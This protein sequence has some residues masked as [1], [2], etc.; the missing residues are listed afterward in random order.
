[1]SR[2]YYNDDDA[3]ERQ[4]LQGGHAD[5]EYDD[6]DDGDQQVEEDEEEHEYDDEHQRYDPESY[7]SQYS[8]QPSRPSFASSLIG[9][10]NFDSSSTGHS[11]MVVRE[12]VELVHDEEDDDDEE[13]E[14][15]I[16]VDSDV[17]QEVASAAER[18]RKALEMIQPQKCNNRIFL[19]L[20]GVVAAMAC[21]F[22]IL[23]PAYY[24]RLFVVG[25]LYIVLWLSFATCAVSMGVCPGRR[26]PHSHCALA[27]YV[28]TLAA[29]IGGMSGAYFYKQAWYFEQPGSAYTNVDPNLG[30]GESNMQNPTFLEFIQNPPNTVRIS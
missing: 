27:L 26:K 14:E 15:E 24:L 30:P 29:Y 9:S 17:E 10:P 1:M 5:H 23:L 22:L 8:N 18:R 12:G 19:Y 7:A 25:L 13:G 2:D 16:E 3:N 21:E 11:S 4:A 28:A 20:L 6:Y